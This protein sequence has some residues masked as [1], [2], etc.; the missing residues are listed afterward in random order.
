MT[1]KQGETSNMASPPALSD[2]QSAR[3]ADW[4]RRLRWKSYNLDKEDEARLAVALTTGGNPYHCLSTTLA[5]GPD[6]GPAS[7]ERCDGSRACYE[8]HPLQIQRR[9]RRESFS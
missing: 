7:P 2:L 5:V 3:P 1:N 9:R 8:E 4:C 6:D